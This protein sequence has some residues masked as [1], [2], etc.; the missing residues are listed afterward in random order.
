MASSERDLL[1]GRLQRLQDLKQWVELRGT[2]G[3]EQRRKDAV[4]VAIAR[5][6]AAIDALEV[7]GRRMKRGTLHHRRTTGPAGYA[8]GGP[9][10]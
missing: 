10:W 1:R 8:G 3:R 4:Q 6:Q 9:A 5:V 2:N 7:A